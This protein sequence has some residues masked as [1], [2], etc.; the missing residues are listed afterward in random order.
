MHGFGR[1]LKRVKDD[2]LRNSLTKDVFQLFGILIDTIPCPSCRNHAAQYY[3]SHSLGNSATDIALFETWIF[4]FHN[5]VNR[6]LYKPVLSRAEADR[7]S[8][9]I[10]PKETLDMYFEAINVHI[11]PNI[12]KQLIQTTAT[13]ILE[14]IKNH[15]YEE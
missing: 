6:R 7:V 15:T 13:Q 14:T 3:K 4:E 10:Q 12:N 5:T 9:S 2:T 11:K 8:E 1:L